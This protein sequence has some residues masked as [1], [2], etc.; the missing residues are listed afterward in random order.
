M[1]GID[2]AGKAAASEESLHLKSVHPSCTDRDSFYA[3]QHD[4][5]ILRGHADSQVNGILQYCGKTSSL[6][7]SRKQTNPVLVILT[8]ICNPLASPSCRQST[9]SMSF[10]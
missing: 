5:P 1:G 2:Y 6:C 9:W 3:V 8:H 7:G 10:L 4:L